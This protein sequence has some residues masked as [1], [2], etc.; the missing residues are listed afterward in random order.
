MMKTVQITMDES[1]LAEIDKVS[2]PSGLELS[3]II[4]DALKHWLKRYQSKRFGQEWIAALK[5]NPDDAS[6]AEAWLE[7]QVWSEQ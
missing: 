3:R 2:E 4:E 5:K 6:R 1:L 7:T